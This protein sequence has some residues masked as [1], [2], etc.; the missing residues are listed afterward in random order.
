MPPYQSRSRGTE[1]PGNGP[2]LLE[3]LL[4]VRCSTAHGSST[5]DGSPAKQ[6]LGKRTFAT[7][8]GVST[9]SSGKPRASVSCSG[10]QDG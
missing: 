2:S 6:M 4:S 8:P 5:S 9:N 3:A 7:W 1:H 10:A